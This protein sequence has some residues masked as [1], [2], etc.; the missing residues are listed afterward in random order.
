[1]DR[2]LLAEWPNSPQIPV[3][4]E[5]AL[6]DPVVFDIGGTWS[7]SYV[8]LSF[9]SWWI[10]STGSPGSQ[11]AKKTRG[12]ASD[13]VVIDISNIYVC[14]YFFRRAGSS[15]LNDLGKEVLEERRDG[16]WP[17]PPCRGTPPSSM[18]AFSQLYKILLQTQF[19]EVF[20]V[21]W[22]ALE[23]W[24][25]T[26]HCAVGFQDSN[27]LQQTSKTVSAVGS[28][29]VERELALHTQLHFIVDNVYWFNTFSLAHQ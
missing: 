17:R 6:S 9:V 24:K 15:W 19:C 16:G 20:D 29:T 1:M 11:G 5:G 28:Y 18:P 27:A 7:W 25:P 12:I 13:P 4:V 10:L 3:K 8:T 14:C 2:I 22:S 26:V 21:C 23:S